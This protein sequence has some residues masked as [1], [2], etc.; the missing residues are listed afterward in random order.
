MVKFIETSIENLY[1]IELEPFQDDR[2]MFCRLFCMDELKKIGFKKQIMQINYSLTIQKGVVRGMHFQYPPK[3]EIKFV[4]CISGKIFDVAIDLRMNSPTFLQ[5]NGDILSAE[6]MKMK[7]I[8]DGFAHGFQTLEK[9]CELLYFH[10]NF[11]C[12]DYEDGIRYDDPIVNI[13]W[14][15]KISYISKRDEELKYLTKDFIGIKV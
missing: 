1:I 12:Q 13:K 5:W 4:R 10:T 2:G 3:T 15:L 8:P 14:P 6:N 11:Y 7:F 9:N